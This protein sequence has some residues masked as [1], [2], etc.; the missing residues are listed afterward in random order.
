MRIEAR[1][2]QRGRR[3]E[4][5]RNERASAFWNFCNRCE[6][7]ALGNL[8]SVTRREYVGC[9]RTRLSPGCTWQRAS[10]IRLHLENASA[11]QTMRFLYDRSRRRDR[12]HVGSNIVSGRMMVIMFSLP[13][14]T[15][16]ENTAF[17]SSNS[18]DSY[19]ISFIFFFL[20][21]PGSAVLQLRNYSCELNA[22]ESEITLLA[23]AHFPL[24]SFST[25]FLVVTVA[26]LMM[27]QYREERERVPSLDIP[28][29]FRVA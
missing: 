7:T 2:R 23:A 18:S 21:I 13:R 5:E 26:A 12:D 27:T 25:H 24:I 15:V 1:E 20:F 29:I 3:T 4:R 16:I 10:M 17:S 8:G 22:A 14:D 19:K 6:R 9:T 28:N 11:T